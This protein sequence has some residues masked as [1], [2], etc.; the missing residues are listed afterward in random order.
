MIEESTGSQFLSDLYEG[1]MSV[2]DMAVEQLATGGIS[3][4]KSLA[5]GLGAFVK[6]VGDDVAKAFI[7]TYGDDAIRA[8]AS[9]GDDAGKMLALNSAD[10][11]AKLLLSSGDD[12]GKAVLSTGDDI[13]D[14]WYGMVDDTVEGAAGSWDDVAS[15][16]DDVTDDALA[17]QANTGYNGSTGAGDSWYKADGSLNLPPNYGAVKG[18]EKIVDL[19]PGSKL[20]R[21][22]TYGK[23]SDFVTAPGSAAETLSLPPY[24]D[25]SI[26]QEFTVLKP[27]PGV[28][29]STV[30]P[31]GG[32]VGGGMQYR[33][34]MTI[35]DL[36][37]NGYIC[38]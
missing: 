28:T 8:I 1:G 15:S 20:G 32:S 12:L 21:F 26:Y 2:V 38:K 33:L 29:Q 31:W 6:A 11:A 19:Q 10:A 23:S 17:G 3:S 9:Y 24:T 18:T 36:L 25:T 16:L 5:K 30:A 7:K 34:P 37:L 27:I 13:V 4:I 35:E 22:G 14:N